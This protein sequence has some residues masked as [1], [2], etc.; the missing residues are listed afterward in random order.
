MEQ[1]R[2]EDGQ[3]DGQ[4]GV[5]VTGMR[6]SASA[7]AIL[8]SRAEELRILREDLAGA[9]GDAI[10]AVDGATAPLA[11]GRVGAG[12]GRSASAGVGSVAGQSNGLGE[13]T[14]LEE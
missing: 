4:T 13:V 3:M 7:S 11:P 1:G 9:A 5:M 14:D 10:A 2:L 8:L 6:T 12:R